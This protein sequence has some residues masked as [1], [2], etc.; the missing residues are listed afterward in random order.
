[1]ALPNVDINFVNSGSGSEPLVDGLFGVIAQAEA[2][3]QLLHNTSVTISKFADL[4]TFGIVDSIANH[5]LFKFLEEFYSVAPEG[6]KLILMIIPRDEQ[7]SDQFISAVGAP[8]ASKLM[9]ESGDNIRG[10]FCVYNPET[11]N[12]IVDGIDSDCWE[13]RSNANNWAINYTENQKSPVWVISQAYNYQGIVSALLNL[14]LASTN[15]FGLVLGDREKRTGTTSQYGSSLGLVAGKL[16]SISVQRNPGRRRDGAITLD[17]MYIVDTPIDQADVAAI[18]DKGYITF[19]TF[20]K[21]TGA[22]ISDCP[23]ATS[24][25]DDYR[26]LTTRR[27]V[28]KAAIIA[29]D[30]LAEEILEDIVVTNSGTIDP[31]YAKQIEGRIS[32]QI[33]LQMTLNGELSSDNTNPN[34]KGCEVL[35]DLT[36]PFASTSTLKFST[37]KVRPKGYV[38]FVDVPI[39]VVDFSTN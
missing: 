31:I 23:L 32:N 2:T 20:P 5:D 15:R 9:Q 37:F 14:T 8:L 29:Y 39:G 25:S 3:P 17:K 33:R 34:D 6:T 27:V 12:L 35:I 19:R 1:M 18:H 24:V 10:V 11:P 13:L 7:M 38:R 26:Y 21:K 16:A 22:F 36:H 4:A 30:E 28:D